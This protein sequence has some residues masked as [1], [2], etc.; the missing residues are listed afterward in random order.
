[1]TAELKGIIPAL[2]TPFDAGGEIDEK[3]FRSHTRFILDKK[4]HG[5]CLGGSTGEGFTLDPQELR[6]LTEITLDEVNGSVPVVAGIIAN[7]T[8]EV[9][10][11]ATALKGLEVAAL[12][13]T[14]TF[15]VFDYGEEAMFQYFKRIWEETGVPLVIYNV[16]P[17]NLLSAD[18]VIRLLEEIPGIIG[19]KQSQGNISR[20]AELVIRAPKG[21]AILAAIDDLLYP[22]FMMGAQGTLAASPTAAPGPCVRLWDAVQAGDHALALKIHDR[23]V[24]FWHLMGHENLPAL[25]KYCL[26]I[27]GCPV[28]LL[29]RHPMPEA[30]EAQKAKIRP[31]LEALLEFDN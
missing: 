22:C 5:V 18:L 2:V 10:Q 3:L 6:R 15:Y 27:Q 16:I 17:W 9:I 29:P 26:E 21:K 30:S 11:R 8:R 19:I 12:Q 4:V 20:A 13:V 7:S 31:A 28:G 25:V 23:L 14:P 24:P 1:M